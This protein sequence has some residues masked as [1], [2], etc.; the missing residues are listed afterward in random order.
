MMTMETIK[1]TEISDKV[2]VSRKWLFLYLSLLVY[3]SGARFFFLF[4][5]F[6]LPDRSEQMES[7]MNAQVV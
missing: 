3:C 4:I 5:F 7:K 6:S 1:A 2:S